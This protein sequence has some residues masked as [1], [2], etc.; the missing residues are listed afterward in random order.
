ML[1]KKKKAPESPFT[2]NSSL[3]FQRDLKYIVVFGFHLS[4]ASEQSWWI[5]VYLF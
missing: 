2:K 5:S 1:K 4:E 3:S